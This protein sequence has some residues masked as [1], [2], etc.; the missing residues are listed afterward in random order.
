MPA[1]P[2]DSSDRRDR[3]G[4]LVV[5]KALR[6]ANSVQQVAN[7]IKLGIERGLRR[8]YLP[9]LWWLKS[10]SFALPEGLEIV[11]LPDPEIPDD[12]WLIH[13]TFFDLRPLDSSFGKPHEHRRMIH[14]LLPWLKI[15]PDGPPLDDRE[16][17]IHLRSGD[18]MRG[19]GS[20]PGYG[21]P[22]LAFYRHVID[23]QPWD[24]IHLVA[25]DDSHPLIP[26]LRHEC[27]MRAKYAERLGK[28]L[29]GD[30]AFLLRAKKLVASR[31]TFISAISALSTCLREIHYFDSGFC[32]WGKENLS[33]SVWSDL[34]GGYKRKVLSKNWRNNREQRQLML[35]YPSEAVGLKDVFSGC[36]EHH[37]GGLEPIF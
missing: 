21:Q 22:P 37:C 24:R 7:S 28:P 16:L 26:H 32:S 8:V 19:T 23:L 12:D 2:G 31:G 29:S 13:G 5:V 34:K 36:P 27:G 17:V 6:F 25:E 14:S 18:V 1:A 10:G 35:D 20:H 33:I 11:H 30:L 3:E 15:Q 9:N 4:A